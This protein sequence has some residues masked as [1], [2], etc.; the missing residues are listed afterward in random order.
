MRRKLVC[1]HWSSQRTFTWRDKARGT[2]QS[3]GSI[4]REN[5]WLPHRIHGSVN[6]WGLR[7][8]FR[9]CVHLCWKA[10]CWAERRKGGLAQNF[11]PLFTVTGWISL[12]TIPILKLSK[13][14]FSHLISI[15]KISFTQGFTAICQEW[16]Q[17]P[18]IFLLYHIIWPYVFH[19]SS[20][21]S[22]R[23]IYW[24]KYFLVY[25]NPHRSCEQW[26]DLLMMAF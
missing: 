5:A 22:R 6:D 18:N 13:A 24:K 25:R 1:F 23:L 7:D 20:F 17:R 10:G 21:K 14:P 8:S 9:K 15:T 26:I 4:C 19:G 11:N 3:E 2:V 16:G 12:G